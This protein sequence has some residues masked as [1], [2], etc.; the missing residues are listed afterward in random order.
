[1]DVYLANYSTSTPCSSIDN[2]CALKYATRP[3]TVQTQAKTVETYPSH[4]GR[5]LW[6]EIS[7]VADVIVDNGIKHILLIIA[8]EWWLETRRNE[9]RFQCNFA[10]PAAPEIPQSQTQQYENMR[11]FHDGQEEDNSIPTRSRKRWQSMHTPKRFPGL[12]H[13]DDNMSLD[14]DKSHSMSSQ[15][16]AILDKVQYSMSSQCH[17]ILDKAQSIKYCTF[18]L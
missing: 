10:D 14:Y 8:R 18:P 1:M 13:A 5:G 12:S 15:R 11:M 17:A 2:I 3:N 4:D 6:W 7:W 9:H 16:H